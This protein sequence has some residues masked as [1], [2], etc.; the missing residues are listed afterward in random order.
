MTTFFSG[1]ADEHD[2]IVTGGYPG[3]LRDIM[4]I[5]VE[6]SDALPSGAENHFTYRGKAYP[7]K[8]LCD[9][10][11]LEGAEALSVYEE[12]FYAQMPAI[13]KNQFGDGWAYYVATRSNEEF[14]QTL[15][16]DICEEC[17][18]ESLL[19]PQENLEVTMRR[20]ENGRFLFLLNHADR[21]Q[22]TV[23]TEAGCGLL[24]KQ[25]YAAGDVVSVPAK[26]VQI[27]RLQ[28]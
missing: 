6:E 8:L 12:D 3:K 5:W 4:G 13:I 15:M 17:G 14:Y 27:I 28:G 20:N 23:M 21:E 19:A 7:A 26:G 24:E 11:H 10:S 22:E 16:A 18:V 9:L 2:L 1:I 25:E